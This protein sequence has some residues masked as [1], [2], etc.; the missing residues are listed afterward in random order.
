MQWA[1]GLTLLAGGVRRARVDGRD[2]GQA[3]GVGVGVEIEHGSK[4]SL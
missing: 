1:G 3:L 2:Q 4:E